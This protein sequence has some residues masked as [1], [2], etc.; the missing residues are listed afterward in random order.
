MGRNDSR[1]AMVAVR[2]LGCLKNAFHTSGIPFSTYT[3]HAEFSEGI[4]IGGGNM[5]LKLNSK[6]RPW[7]RNF[8]SGFNFVS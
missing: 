6:Q 7:Q 3:V 4:L 2:H 1:P 5:A 8:I